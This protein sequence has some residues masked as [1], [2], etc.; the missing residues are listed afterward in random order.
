M[1]Y[2][3]PLPAATKETEPFWAGCRRHELLLQSCDSCGHKQLYPR[4]LCTRCKTT[5]LSWTPAS[6]KGV[7]HSFTV[8]RRAPSAAFK[9]DVPYVLALIELEE[10]VRLMSNIIDCRPEDVRIDLPVH[11][12]FDDVTETATLPK[13]VLGAT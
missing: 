4:M 2:E 11:V 13:F 6:G 10:G 8:I 12:V 3:K 7:V 9:P 1:A 5:A